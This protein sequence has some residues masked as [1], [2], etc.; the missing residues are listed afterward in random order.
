MPHS[1][2]PALTLRGKQAY[3]KSLTLN[4]I[5]VSILVSLPRY[6]HDHI[7]PLLLH[8]QSL[9]YTPN[10]NPQAYMHAPA[11]SIH[12]PLPLPENP[13]LSPPTFKPDRRPPNKLTLTCP[14]P[15]SRPTHSLLTA[16]FKHTI[17]HPTPPH[18]HIYLAPR[19]TTDSPTN[20]LTKV[21]LH[22]YSMFLPMRHSSTSIL[23]P[24]T[25]TESL[26]CNH[27]AQPR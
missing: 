7:L 22:P 9:T 23:D 15:L 25:L 5:L 13:K 10:L 19:P 18:P 27:P 20:I 6:S 21:K 14:F 3:P 12:D 11:S 4:H 2:T 26:I 17:Q 8:L 24:R 1:R 16:L